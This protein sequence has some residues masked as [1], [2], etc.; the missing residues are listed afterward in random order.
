MLTP[1][2]DMFP[3]TVPL[4]ATN[5]QVAERFY[6]Q[7]SNPEK[8]RQIYLNTLSVQAVNFYLTCLGIRTDLEQN[9]SWNPS[10]QV[11]ADTADLWVHNLGHLE[12]RAV[13]LNTDVC[14]IPPQVWGERIGYVAVQFNA[15]FLIRTND[16]NL[17]KLP[18]H[19]W[20]FFERYPKAEVA[21]SAPEYEAIHSSKSHNDKK[22]PSKKTINSHLAPVAG[23]RSAPATGAV[24]SGA[25]RR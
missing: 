13:L 3:F 2:T 5:H 17:Q 25:S 18:W 4:T 16:L 6:Q 8:A 15:R 14:V 24:L 23:A 11:L 22:F 20:D 10:L 12:C 19:E 21:L 1:Q 7:H 9:Y